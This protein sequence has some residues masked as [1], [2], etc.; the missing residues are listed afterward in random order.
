[1]YTNFDNYSK[2][3]SAK[4]LEIEKI[5]NS[6]SSGRQILAEYRIKQQITRS[7]RT[8]ISRLIAE[9]IQ[10]NYQKIGSSVKLAISKAICKCFPVEKPVSV[11]VILKSELNIK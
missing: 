3:E 10:A 5:L 6:T 2:K 8:R 11:R 4:D 9:H 7:K 1:M